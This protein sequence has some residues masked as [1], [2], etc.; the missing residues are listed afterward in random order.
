[1]WGPRRG[2]SRGTLEAIPQM[3]KAFELARPAVLDGLAVGEGFV[4]EGWRR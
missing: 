3:V 1:M 2:L 4:I